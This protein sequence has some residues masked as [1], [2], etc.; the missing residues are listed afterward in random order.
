M[1]EVHWMNTKE[2]PIL[3]E[4]IVLEGTSYIYFRQVHCVSFLVVAFVEI[5]SFS[6]QT[7]IPSF[8]GRERRSD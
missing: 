6:Y 1:H 4:I 5:R 3:T 2:F 7:G 8:L